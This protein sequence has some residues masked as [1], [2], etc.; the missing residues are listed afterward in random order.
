MRWVDLSFSAEAAGAASSGQKGQ[1]LA[2]PDTGRIVL[3][4]KEYFEAP[5][6]VLP[7]GLQRESASRVV[8]LIFWSV[9]SGCV[10]LRNKY[11][12]EARKR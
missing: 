12:R 2:A 4:E 7:L 11:T 8:S 6:F 5:G 1:L 10:A 9:K 3:T